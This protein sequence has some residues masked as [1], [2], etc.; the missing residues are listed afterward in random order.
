[1]GNRVKSLRR[2]TRALRELCTNHETAQLYA[3]ASCA[4]QCHPE[5]GPA[6]RRAHGVVKDGEGRASPEPRIGHVLVTALQICGRPF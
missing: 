3:Y 5:K 4:V 6:Q 2:L 1:M